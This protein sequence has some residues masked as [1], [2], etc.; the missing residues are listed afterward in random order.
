MTL[1]LDKILA[2]MVSG[3]TLSWRSQSLAM[4]E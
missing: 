4:L 3:S 1:G 2:S